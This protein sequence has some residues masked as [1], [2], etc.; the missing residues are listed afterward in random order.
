M[1]TEGD[2]SYFVTVKDTINKITYAQ[3]YYPGIS[4]ALSPRIY[5]MYQFSGKGKVQAVRHVMSPSISFSY[6]PD[7]SGIVPQY[8]REIRNEEG[9]LLEKYSIYENG[10][11]GTPSFSSRQRTMSLS[12]NNNIE[13]KVKE[14]NDTVSQINK[15]K[16]IDNL[17]FSTSANFEDSILF[18]PVSFNGTT[19]FLKNTLNLSFRGSFDPY[20]IDENQRRINKS[21][22]SKTGK[23]ARLTS[24][25]FST[26]FSFSSKA[27]TS[28]AS[29]TGSRP[30]GSDHIEP[31]PL[32]D[33]YDRFDE[34]YYGEYVDFNIPWSLR[35]DYN[36]NY[37][38]MGH[39][40][41][42]IQTLRISGDFS[43]TPKWKIGYNTGY[44][45]KENKITTSSLS[46]YR[47]LHCW[48]MSLSAVPFG[49]YKSV[50]FQINVKSAVLKDLKYNKR[51]PWQDNF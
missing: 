10:M 5:G 51:I 4:A 37:S 49:Y 46:I 2:T 15:V 43:L 36:F 31:G 6:I 45:F 18:R 25:G 34:D 22:F 35:A 28:D 9:Q 20:A 41:N 33:E 32:T 47:D 7:M 13:M 44:D 30:L 29:E 8:Y 17:S 11:F 21:E 16:I 48:E 14:E 50:N 23:I 39:K 3:G 27:K 38:K 40:A 1:I 12:L 42:L 19:S 24:F 26:G